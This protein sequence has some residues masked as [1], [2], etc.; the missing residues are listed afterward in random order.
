MAKSLKLVVF[1]CDGTLVD[2]QHM[3]CSA[4]S[5]AYQAHGI[6]VP[7]RETMLSI[8]GLS[9]LEAFTV[10]GKGQAG[11]PAASLADAYRLAF[12]AL[13]E[14]GDT[15]EPLYPGAA[16]AV[17]ALA[18]RDGVV[19]GIATGKSQRGVR[20]VLGHHGLLDHFITIKTADDAPSKP[21]P[22][23]V[24]AAMRDVGASA[25]NTVVVGDTIYDVAMAQA[26]GAAPIGVAWG[27]HRRE[28]LAQMGA[29]VIDTFATLGPTLD[30]MW[31]C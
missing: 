31:T 23:M 19:L 16:E 11:F 4:M 3:I 26:A 7:D 2:S 20:L 27:Y 9:L 25:D 22:G 12:H 30:R 14:T 8:V 28:A 17:A 15:I 18:R 21:D 13:R 5:R 24:L 10:L 1:D 6:A 29:P